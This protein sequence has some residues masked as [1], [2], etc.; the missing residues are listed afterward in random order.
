MKQTKKKKKT[1]E[2]IIEIMSIFGK[3]N[4]ID[5]VLDKVIKNRGS[6]FK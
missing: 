4:K 2:E 5:K 6:G 3:D 1:V